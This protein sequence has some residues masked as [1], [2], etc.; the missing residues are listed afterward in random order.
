VQ[1]SPSLAAREGGISG[2][3]A[4]A[5]LVNLP[6]NDCVELGIVP[7]RTRQVEVEQFDAADAPAANVVCQFGC[8]CERAIIHAPCPPQCRDA[9]RI[10]WAKGQP[11]VRARRRPEL[12]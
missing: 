9:H 4:F 5:R 8:R 7:F 1:R 10:S 3:G 2:A 12:I 6:D 11:I